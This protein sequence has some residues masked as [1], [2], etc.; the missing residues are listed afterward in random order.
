MRI[1]K[2]ASAILIGAL[3]FV[4]ASAHG[5][6]YRYAVQQTASTELRTA[7]QAAT[8]AASQQ[9]AAVPVCT[10]A[11]CTENGRHLHN[12]VL[13]CGAEHTGSACD[14]SCLTHALC[15]VEG[16]TVAGQHVHDGV[17]YCG[18][19]HA[20]GV[21]DG[22]CQTYALC[23]VEGCTTAG[24]HQ[25]DS[26]TYCGSAHGCGYCDG[27]CQTVRQGAGQTAYPSGR[28]HHH[29]GHH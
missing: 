17:L 13:Y 9:A 2:A 10:V 18:A 7:Q 1:H 29:G 12:N 11:D 6:C 8:T 15:T 3:L 28:G 26:V 25:H 4:S 27:A 19:E 20:G 5:G 21:C 14:G 23:P 22:S 24:Q 16:C